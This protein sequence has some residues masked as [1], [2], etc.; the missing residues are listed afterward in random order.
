M[1]VVY[2]L[3]T[4]GAIVCG[5]GLFVA[6]DLI[7]AADDNKEVK[8]AILKIADAIEKKDAAAPN[9]AAEF[10]KKDGTDLDVIMELFKPRAKGGMGVG[11]K[12]GLVKRDGIEIK[13]QDLDKT[14]PTP[15]EA[16]AESDAL[17]RAGYVAAAIADTVK[18][19]VPAEHKKKAKEWQNLSKEMQ[20]AGIE[21]AEAAK[22]KKPADIQKAAKQLN[23]SCIKCH[24]VFR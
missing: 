16:Q 20:K 21:F 15:R 12:T 2:K 10:A 22:T 24:D 7:R 18:G 14:T 13:L 6:S 8:K 5:L 17:A 4:G 3:L 19:K 11:D 9:L 23:D 1:T